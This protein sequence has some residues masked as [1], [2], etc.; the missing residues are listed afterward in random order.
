MTHKRSNEK[1]LTAAQ[2][3][4]KENSYTSIQ[5]HYGFDFS[6]VLNN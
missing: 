1:S 4:E 6:E 5:F 2:I 3:K